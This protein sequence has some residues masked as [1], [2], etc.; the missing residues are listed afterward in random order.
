MS[1]NVDLSALDLQEQER[2]KKIEKLDANQGRKK[3]IFAGV[4]VFL[5]AL[6][7]FGTVFGA[8]YI[9]SY[10]GTAELPGMSTSFFA[11]CE[12]ADAVNALGRYIDEACDY[13]SVKLDTRYHVSVPEEDIR[14]TADGVDGEKLLK[15]IRGS[16]EGKLSGIYSANDKNGAYGEDFS[17]EL[18][19]FDFAVSDV[20]E[21]VLKLNEENEAET[22]G[23]ISFDG[24]KK[25][26]LS[27]LPVYTVFDM[28]DVDVIL[29][30]VI[31][32]FASDVAVSGLKVE[33]DKFDIDAYAENLAV[34]A[35]VSYIPDPVLNRI[36]YSRSCTVSFDAEFLGELAPYGKQHI[37]M[38]VN[39]SEEYIFTHVKFNIVKDVYFIEK[40]DS[41][42]INRKITSDE[43]V[44][45]I[46]V[47][48]TSSDP[49]ILS[50]DKKGFY[51]GHKI[52]DAPVTVT[53]KYVY[54][55][56]EYTDS[57]QFYVRVPVESVKLSE[58]ELKLKVGEEKQLSPII[59]PEKATFG[60]VY[61][62]TTD[63]N[64]AAVDENGN[65]K[66]VA[67]GEAGVYVITFDGNFKK[68]CTVSVTE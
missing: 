54:N 67:P 35:A 53:G 49:D 43:G 19:D 40:G 3:F 45:D 64:V 16:I 38:R 9:L 50:V 8:K 5:I 17:T 33:Y 14:V 18:P 1:D 27:S 29:D 68:T 21:A 66:A 13:A 26:E 62:F 63:E 20:N 37:S 24:C 30:E 36:V 48:W 58:K 25:E 12:G 47:E 6:F 23:H 2:L 56:V 7:A 39:V 65:V 42:E 31:G 59:K 34:P 51:K 55:G 60:N 57:V 22:L 61:W 11:D 46:K 4:T 32:S 10:E 41:D 15:F 52:S 28:D 44:T